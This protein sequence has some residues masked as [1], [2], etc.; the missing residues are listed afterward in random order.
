MF[1]KIKNNPFLK[2]SAILFVGTMIVNV[3]NYIF[4]LLL[5]RM[6]PIELYGEIE[7]LISLSH[8]ISIPAATLGMI[9]TKYSAHTKADDNP[10]GSQLIFK[11]FN[12]KIINFGIPLFLLILTLTPLVK[13]FL[14]IEEYWPIILIWVLMLLGLFSAISN[15]I[16]VGWQKFR[17]TSGISIIG[18]TVKIIVGVGLLKL[19]FGASGVIG[20][21]VLSGITVY[22]LTVLT[23]K[24]TK[25]KNKNSEKEVDFLAMKKYLLP[26]LMG[27]VS[28]TILSNVDMVLAKNKLDAISSGQYG[29]LSVASKAIFFATGVLASVLFSMSAEENHK[30]GNS[31]RQLR[32]AFFLTLLATVCATTFYFLFPKF[33]L[34]VFFGDKYLD[35]ASY[36]GWFAVM[37][38]LFSFSHLFIQY[39]L[40]IQKTRAAFYF[41]AIA[42]VEILAIFFFANSIY[43][44]VS[45]VIIIQIMAILTGLYFI[46]SDKNKT[47]E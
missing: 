1:E 36:L 20:G 26:A 34:G 15:G 3:L 9:V 41:L 13:N 12:Q 33:V 22:I 45:I 30:K 16:L 32:N 10:Y 7:S 38:S 2:N 28:I 25:T 40:S 37:V 21:F 43:T 46:L 35:V 31:L 4:H 44:I 14:K 24:F 39:L 11:A 18:T 23:L 5:G 42:L 8:I 17:E 19:G 47:Y 27:I 6:A 29:A